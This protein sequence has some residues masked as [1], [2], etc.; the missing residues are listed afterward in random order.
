MTRQQVIKNFLALFIK[1]V[2]K[3]ATC[4]YCKNHTEEKMWYA[5]DHDAIK[6]KNKY[7]LALSDVIENKIEHGGAIATFNATYNF[8]AFLAGLESKELNKTENIL[9]A[10]AQKWSAEVTDTT[11]HRLTEW[12][13]ESGGHIT[14]LH[15]LVKEGALHGYSNILQT[16]Q[17]MFYRKVSGEVTDAIEKVTS[18]NK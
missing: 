7:Y 2:E 4:Q 6:D 1:H 9:R 12:L 17:Y 3:P 5:F 8:L 11:D 15:S 10:L 13:N 16:A 14:Y 18:N